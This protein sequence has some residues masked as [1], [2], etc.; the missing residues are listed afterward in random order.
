MRFLSVGLFCVAIALLYYGATMLVFVPGYP[1]E[2][3]FSVG[4]LVYGVGPTVASLTMIVLAAK[5]W[6]A[7]RDCLQR[8]IGLLLLLAS[9]CVF[10]LYG[11]LYLISTRQGR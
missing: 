4:R 3:Y 5:T 6:S 1:G 10:A 2:R 9:T 7:R 8:R 11:V